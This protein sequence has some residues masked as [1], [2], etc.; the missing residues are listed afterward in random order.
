[1]QQF[2]LLLAYGL[3]SVTKARHAVV[4]NSAYIDSPAYRTMNLLS[5]TTLIVLLYVCI[6]NGQNTGVRVVFDSVT[7]NSY[8]VIENAEELMVCIRVEGTIT[9]EFSVTLNTFSAGSA[10]GGVDYTDTTAT[11]TFIPF[12]TLT[13]CTTTIINDD[14]MLEG[15]EFFF[16]SVSSDDS[17]VEIPP[18]ATVSITNDD[19]VVIG[20][21]QTSYSAIEGIPGKTCVVI[22]SGS[23]ARSVSFTVT[24]TGGTAS[25]DDYIPAP[26]T[27]SITV[28]NE[29]VCVN[30]LLNTDSIVED[31]ET[32]LLTVNS[33]NSSTTATTTLN[34][35]DNDGVTVQLA[36]TQLSV[37]EGNSGT[38]SLSLC[39]LLTDVQDNLDRDVTLLLNTQPSSA[40]TSDFVSLV[41]QPLTI[42]M[43]TGLFENVC[44]QLAVNGDTVC[45]QSELYS[46]SVTPM[47]PLDMVTGLVEVDI[48]ILDDGDSIEDCG[49]LS[50]ASGTVQYTATTCGSVS[51]YTCVPG[52]ILEGVGSRTCEATGSLCLGLWSGSSTTCRLANCGLLPSLSNG[53]VSFSTTTFN[54]VAS[55]TCDL[56]Y[57]LIGATSCTCQLD[58]QWSG[59]A[60]TCDAVQCLSISAPDNGGLIFTN[61]F[62]FNSLARYSCEG[63]YDISGASIRICR[64]IGSWSAIAPTC[65]PVDCMGL[66]N[67]ANGMV[68]LSSTTFTHTATYSCLSGFALIGQ[69]TRECLETQLW[70]G[71]EPTCVVECGDLPIPSNGIV[72]YSDTTLI[73]SVA[74]FTCSESYIVTGDSTR[75]CLLTGMWSGIQPSCER[76]DCGLLTDPQFGSVTLTPG[77]GLGSVT[78]Y[79]CNTGYEPSSTTDR[80][81]LGSGV[82]SGDMPTCSLID[83]GMPSSLNNGGQV[84]VSLTT[85]GSFSVY[86]CLS[87]Y[88]LSAPSSIRSCMENGNWS[89]LDPTCDLIDCGT[90]SSLNNGGQVTVSLTTFGSFSVYT[91]PSGY[92]LSAP[93]SIRSCMENGNWS[94]LDPICDPI[95]CGPRASP[96]N[97]QVETTP[98]TTF[99]STATY[100][101]SNG[102]DLVGITERVCEA[103]GD[104]SLQGSPDPVC[105][106][107]DCGQL[108]SPSNGLVTVSVTTFL[109]EAMYSCSNG[110]ILMGVASRTCMADRNWSDAEPTCEPVVCPSLSNPANGIVD[111]S[112][113]TSLN[114]VATYSCNVGYRLEGTGQ[115][116]C[117]SEGGWSD[118]QPVCE[119]VT[120]P[121]DRVNP[122]NGAIQIITGLNFGSLVTYLCDP[123]YALIGTST[124]TC[125]ANG[126]WT[127][128][129]PTCQ[130]IGCPDRANPINGTSIRLTANVVQFS[131]DRGFTLSDSILAFS[132]CEPTT[133]LW[134]GPVPS[135][136]IEDCGPPPAISD[137]TVDS[138]GTVYLSEAAY[139]CETGFR[140]QPLASS[141]RV[142]EVGGVW[143]GENG[144]CQPVDCGSLS[145]PTNGMV[146]LDST[147][148]G[149]EAAYSCQE[150]YTLVGVALRVCM[151][152]GEWSEEEPL[153]EDTDECAL[154]QDDCDQECANTEGG[155]EC[156]CGVG[157][158][159]SG[160]SRCEDID[161]CLSSKGGCAQLCVNNQGSRECDCL[162]GFALDQD[163]V[164]CND[165]DECFLSEDDCHSNASCTNTL[166]GFSC[167]CQQGFQGDGRTCILDCGLLPPLANGTITY[168]PGTLVGGV[169]IHECD[170]GFIVQ[171]GEERVCLEGGE[172]ESA[173]IF[174]LKV[175][176]VEFE[177][178]VYRVLETVG[179]ALL[180]VIKR[181]STDREVNVFFNTRAG[182]AV[183]P[184]DYLERQNLKL[185]LAPGQMEEFVTI[186]IVDGAGFRDNVTVFGVLSTTD[187][188]VTVGPEAMITIIEDEPPNEECVSLES[189]TNGQIFLNGT[190][191]GDTV[192]YQCDTGFNLVG[193]VNRTCNSV[194]LWTSSQPTCQIADCGPLSNPPNGTVTLSLTTYL[195]VANYSCDP[196]SFRLEGTESR[197][198]TEE[199]V[200]SPEEPICEDVFAVCDECH[201]R[202]SCVRVGDLQYGCECLRGFQGDGLTCVDV[203]ECARG[204]G[205]CDENANCINTEGGHS[206]VCRPGYRGGGLDCQNID[207]CSEASHSCHQRAIC[208][209]TEGS[210]TC[211]CRPGFEGDGFSCEAPPCSSD[212]QLVLENIVTCSQ[213]FTAEPQAKTSDLTAGVLTTVNNECGDDCMLLSSQI[214]NAQLDCTTSNLAVYRATLDV[215][216][217]ENCTQLIAILQ[218]WISTSPSLVVQSVRIRIASYC[219]VEFESFDIQSDCMNPS[220]NGTRPT[221]GTQ[222]TEQTPSG[223]SEGVQLSMIEIIAVSAVGGGVALLLILTLLIICC[224]FIVRISRISKTRP[225]GFVEGA[226][227][228]ND[229]LS[230]QETSAQRQKRIK[231]TYVPDLAQGSEFTTFTS[232]NDFTTPALTSSYSQMTT[233]LQGGDTIMHNQGVADIE[234]NY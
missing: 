37:V 18:L 81:C 42:P 87:G 207:E 115:R 225:P 48:T 90:P 25:G 32:V 57:I 230:F 98:S 126:L 150:N 187:V 219:E 93:S 159:Q 114:A 193:E 135:C 212:F 69:D 70:S 60:P 86:T 137:G 138:T 162:Q 105:N 79:A 127:D 139:S 203:D 117:G 113:G 190:Q 196:E 182:T 89:G 210:F 80:T 100:S 231:P 168:T 39:V 205:N 31:T 88:V 221:T 58:E 8:T 63:G 223:E 47:N 232:S 179:A 96:I 192:S 146:S 11:H 17:S 19:T 118:T 121:D 38:S 218:D 180:R 234:F 94:G 24:Q 165:I 161:E 30:L 68:A 9:Q 197:V 95:D 222:A 33:T 174:C 130:M 188:G 71:E 202:A 211:V 153:C 43:T 97:G 15:T 158:R 189:P 200:W 124:Q 198:C 215:T 84:T 62:I 132:Q 178:K 209:D 76:V 13:R 171:G 26:L 227:A 82:W 99:T 122:I 28:A 229:A 44:F 134:S 101:C 213:W 35:L 186:S 128:E 107:V 199:G 176:H 167:S 173:V 172:W 73:N 185:T 22:V 217:G 72:S 131:C 29:P 49:P 65:Q 12:S 169:A 91:C 147:L 55:Y 75:T 6:A 102:Y 108:T 191:I 23:I 116:T 183:A 74:T 53:E 16:I 21:N 66:N 67:P 51:T 45:E 4:V 194:G 233:P 3:D 7:P 61:G 220:D 155:Y 2:L 195:S 111:L 64:S 77:T 144:A 166:G 145:N 216:N 164:N 59:D 85:F 123:T 170:E 54:S 52:F 201:P 120:C 156:S 142:C 177:P 119:E 78:T 184:R 141:V 160:F 143:S 157:Y 20:F 152:N 106:P 204:S 228:S 112:Q 104:W 10:T 56:G 149:S 14:N 214:T 92:V 148:R 226:S 83:C 41:D 206:C 46:V 50:V 208:T 136:I 110:Y 224:V 151:D 140:V 103:D 27:G 133:G 1:M 181:N 40:D 154:G 5:V 109:S 36:S 175:V 34:I 129:P 125:E 163:D